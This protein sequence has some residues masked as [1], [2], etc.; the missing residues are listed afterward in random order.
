VEEQLQRLSELLALIGHQ[1]VSEQDLNRIE[2]ST[3]QPAHARAQG[4][5]KDTQSLDELYQETWR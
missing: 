1:T 4:S 2:A 3:N 5:L